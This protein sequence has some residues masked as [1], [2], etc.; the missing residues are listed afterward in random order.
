MIKTAVESYRSKNTIFVK[1]FAPLYR[2]NSKYRTAQ[3][4]NKQHYMRR[5]Q[6][7]TR[8]TYITRKNF[9]LHFAGAAAV[10]ARGSS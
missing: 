8:L 10:G 1:P 6:E 3:Y 4:P 5:I 2:W 7:V 9:I